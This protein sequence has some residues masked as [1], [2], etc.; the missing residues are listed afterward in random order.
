MAS[1]IGFNVHAT[2]QFFDKNKLYAHIQKT[3]PAWMLIMDGLQVA[4]DVKQLVPEC[5]VIYRAWPDEETWKHGSPADW[6]AAKKKEIGDADVWAYTINEQSLPDALCDWFT[7][8][9]EVSAS[10]HLKVIIGNPSVGTPAPEQWRSPA[11]L[12]MLHAL[13]K[14][15]DTAIL[16]LHEYFLL[17]PTSGVLGGWPDSAG[18][19]PGDKGGVNLVPAE[20]WP[21]PANM[22]LFTCFHMGRFKFMVEACKAN[23]INPPR[24]VLTESGPDDVSDIKAWADQQ[25]KTPPYTGIRGWKSCP[26][27]WHKFYPQWT[28]EETLFHM[29]DWADKSIY[30]GTCVEAE[31]MFC[32]G[33]SSDMW[34]QFDLSQAFEFQRLLETRQVTIPMPP[35]I[36]NPIPPAPPLPPQFPPAPIPLDTRAQLAAMKARVNGIASLLESLANDIQILEDKLVA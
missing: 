12:K 35:Q 30:Q 24:V 18:V 17:V 33:H 1:R 5:N 15:R 29:M 10:A 16:G 4:R 9:I 28:A 27:A 13:D 22:K 36:P 11:A 26:N 31:L 34:D 6:V 21:T 2:S 25:P 8:V 20:S 32:W 19:K 23:G 14:H 3:R 7:A